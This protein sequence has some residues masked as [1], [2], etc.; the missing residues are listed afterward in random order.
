VVTGLLWDDNTNSSCAPSFADN[1]GHGFTITPNSPSN[2][3][4]VLSAVIYLAYLVVPASPSAIINANFNTTGPSGLV[5]FWV[6]EY[7]P[8]QSVISL[9][10]DAAGTG[11]TGTAVNTPT[12][13]VTGAD[14]LCIAIC[15]GDHIISSVD[16]PW[17]QRQAGQGVNQYSEGIGDILSRASNVAVAMTQNVSAGWDSMAASFKASASGGGSGPIGR[18]VQP[19]NNTRNTIVLTAVRNAANS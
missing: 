7:S 3:R 19:M 8:P 4:P 10:S 13:T 11:T 1:N 6:A 16:T 15:A 12:L 2:A 18:E 17:S 14:D 9:D 5:T